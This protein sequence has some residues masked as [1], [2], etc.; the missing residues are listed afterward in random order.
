MHAAQLISL[1]FGISSASALAASISYEGSF[2]NTQNATSSVPKFNPA[3]GV[4][5]SVTFNLVTTASALVE[6]ESETPVAGPAAANLSCSI[7]GTFSGLNTSVVLNRS[8]AATYG[9]DDEVAGPDYTGVDYKSFGV[10]TESNSNSV[11]ATSALAG[12]IGNGSLGV[13][14]M[15]TQPWQVASTGDYASR[16]APGSSTTQW[17]VVYTFTPAIIPEPG[18][19]LLGL[20]SLLGLVVRRRR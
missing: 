14:V 3:I 15:E 19:S 16:I 10:V 5:E 6:V 17:A 7:A 11:A 18:T 12:Y 8:L 4:L 9:A 20:G 2:V 1:L 13:N